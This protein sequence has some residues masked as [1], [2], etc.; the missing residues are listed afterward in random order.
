MSAEIFPAVVLTVCLLMLAFVRGARN[1]YEEA[2]AIAQTAATDRR[3]AQYDVRQ[4]RRR[5]GAGAK[6]LA[7]MWAAVKIATRFAWRHLTPVATVVAVVALLQLLEE[8]VL[9][10]A[11]GPAAVVLG[12]L[13]GRAALARRGVPKAPL[14]PIKPTVVPLRQA[15]GLWMPVLTGS[16]RRLVFMAAAAL[17]PLAAYLPTEPATAVA[18]L[19]TIAAVG[20]YAVVSHSSLRGY[21]IAEQERV[22]AEQALLEAVAVAAGCASYELTLH[23]S[24]TLDRKVLSL[25]GKAYGR[26]ATDVD[27]ALVAAGLPQ[28]EGSLEAIPNPVTGGSDL[29]L[30]LAPAAAE[31]LRRRE[32]LDT[33]GGLVTTVNGPNRDGR[34]AV[35]L[36][37]GVSPARADQVNAWAGRELNADLIE[38]DPHNA[39]AVVA[40]LSP[41][42]RSAR[43]RIAEVAKLEAH[44]LAIEVTERDGHLDSILIPAAPVLDRDPTKRREAWLQV[45]LS[46][47]DGTN[48]WT[49][50]EDATRGD[51]TLTWGPQR[52]L[53]ATVA[54]HALLPAAP[55]PDAWSTLPIGVGEDGT[56]RGFDLTLGPHSLLVGPTGSGKTVG[57]LALAT[58]Q[59]ARGFDVAIIDPTKGGVDFAS[60]EPYTRGFARKFEDA[61]ALIKAVYAEGQR[62]KPMLLQ[63]GAVKWDELPAAVREA[64]G[65]RPVSLIIDELASLLAEAVVPKGLPK[66]DPD[67][68]DAQELN[69]HKA[70]LSLYIGKIARELRFVGIHLL[71]AMQRPD[72]AFFGGGEGRSNLTSVLQLA[73]PGSPPS[74][75]AI[76]MVFTGDSA[77]EAFETLRALD[78]GRSRGL[79]VVAGDGGGV[80]GVRV[81][82]ARMR[83]IAMMLA[84]RG[85][86]PTTAAPFTTNFGESKRT[87]G[88]RI[89]EPAAE[90]IIDL[91][92][93]FGD[94]SSLFDDAPDPWEQA[95]A[96]RAAI[97]EPTQVDVDD[98]F[99]PIRTQP[100][101]RRTH[102]DE[103]FGASSRELPADH[104]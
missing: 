22:R 8:P 3:A 1:P 32:L 79:G 44:R 30:T 33:S 99:G 31:T 42:A 7:G 34:Y 28:W 10:W 72:A 51:V 24:S 87:P 86:H 62:R 100:D 103:G 11:A 20:R 18:G 94:L 66:D 39:R 95:A 35:L 101:D 55:D 12:L 23:P 48:G 78:D 65:V 96:T 46:L 93:D 41:N 74:L 37:P 89:E 52:E 85:I 2:P 64:E 88:R 25:P 60:I 91:D 58:Q 68:L 50:A 77:Q 16:P 27:A 54:L 4:V 43:A 84:E 17:L 19:V 56:P 73:K 49:Y 47:P 81:A 13:I 75:D 92:V 6:L 63:H 71:L 80:A 70:I 29:W 9:A 38:W 61:T 15:W 45:V 21:L 67:V 97:A 98:L 59:L 82:Y 76:R 40:R 36:S 83:D 90:A 53:P 14:D 104:F 69:G 57:I 5:R 26:L 102:V